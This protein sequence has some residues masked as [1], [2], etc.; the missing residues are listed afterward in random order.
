MTDGV[1]FGKSTA[2]VQAE[3]PNL[4]HDDSVREVRARAAAVPQD[5]TADEREKLT[6]LN[7]ILAQDRP[8]R[9]NVPR[10]FYL[11]IQI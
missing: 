2:L 8:L 11:N 5:T 10:G 9:R 7:R 4:Y 1:S 3:R 6:R